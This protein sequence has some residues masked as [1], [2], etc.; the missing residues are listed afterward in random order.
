MWLS[1]IFQSLYENIWFSFIFQNPYENMHGCG[2]LLFS[3]SQMET[4]IYFIWIFSSNVVYGYYINCWSKKGYLNYMVIFY[5]PKARWKLPFTSY[6]CFH[7][8]LCMVIT[9]IAG[10]KK[11]TWTTL[12]PHPSVPYSHPW[13]VDRVVQQSTGWWPMDE[14]AQL[15]PC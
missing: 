8:T 6:G 9:S 12:F 10:Q 1:F 15:A 7:L 2:Y 4:T 5:F 13:P 11:V 14:P 3:Q